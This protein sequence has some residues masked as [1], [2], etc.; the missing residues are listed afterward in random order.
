M[1]TASC[2]ALEPANFSTP[3]WIARIANQSRRSS[4]AKTRAKLLQQGFW[5]QQLSWDEFDMDWEDF[6]KEK[7]RRIYGF[8]HLGGNVVRVDDPLCVANNI[9]RLRRAVI[10]IHL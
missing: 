4:E 5:E 1:L 7:T 2:E 6:V 10:P 9:F 3:V 8:A